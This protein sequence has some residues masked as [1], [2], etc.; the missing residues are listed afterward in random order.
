MRRIEAGRR[1]VPDWMCTWLTELGKWL[2]AHP[3]PRELIDEWE[4]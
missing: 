1:D 3:P 2:D 4:D